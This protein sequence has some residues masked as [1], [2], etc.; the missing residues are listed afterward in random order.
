MPTAEARTPS[1][2]DSILNSG[3]DP[4]LISKSCFSLLS[5]KERIYSF[6]KFIP[7]KARWTFCGYTQLQTSLPLQVGLGESRNLATTGKL[8][9]EPEVCF[10]L[11]R[12]DNHHS[13]FCKV[14]DTIDEK[15]ER[16]E[17][18]VLPGEYIQSSLTRS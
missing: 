8:E 3:W 2:V 9:G 15:E 13:S 14:L 6:Q 12:P 17:M 1:I 16:L 4:F 7:R 18:I 5:S 11:P 10:F